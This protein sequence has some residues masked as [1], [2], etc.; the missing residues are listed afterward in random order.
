MAIL[1]IFQKCPP[2]APH[3][4]MLDTRVST[5]SNLLLFICCLHIE[6]K[7]NSTSAKTK[8]PK[9]YKCV[10]D[11]QLAAG[12][13]F[14]EEEEEKLLNFDFTIGNKVKWWCRRRQRKIGVLSLFTILFTKGIN[15]LL[16]TAMRASRYACKTHV[17]RQKEQR[18]CRFSENSSARDAQA[19]PTT[20][21]FH[22]IRTIFHCKS[23]KCRFDIKHTLL[24]SFAISRRRFPLRMFLT[25][26]AEIAE[27]AYP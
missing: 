2:A 20:C 5:T 17:V 18:K 12:N 10:C 16:Q 8:Q 15:Y 27:N 19:M 11:A 13:R 23:G 22:K 3:S 6:S 14:I 7:Q 9:N 4:H 25:L 21:S 24:R 1:N 26:R